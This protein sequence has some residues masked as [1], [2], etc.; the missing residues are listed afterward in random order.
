MA[1]QLAVEPIQ[2]RLAGAPIGHRILYLPSV[3]STMDVARREAEQ[4]APEGTVV[5]AEVQ[6]AGRG[7]FGRRWVSV[8]GE[9]LSFS[10]LL[11]PDRDACAGLSITAPVA[12]VRAIRRVTGLSPALKWP[13][14]VL[15][16]GKKV[17]GILIETA[18]QGDDVQYAIVGIGINVNV[19][20]TAHPE[21]AAAATSL[22]GEL[23][24]SVSR[25]ELFEAVLVDLGEIYGH[26][27]AWT[28]VRQEWQASLETL[29][30]EIQVRWGDQIEEGLAEAVDAEG[31]LLLR[32]H[33]G[34]VI[35]LPGGEVTS[36]VET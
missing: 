7:R 25:E 19:D 11:Y 22:A 26:L 23:G 29:G 30:K 2:A 34:T 15:L 27:T 5:V 10:F 12:V 20:P 32:R 24:A 6:T 33:D 31:N 28:G 35:V 18:F 17:C 36:Q 13:N 16:D 1:V 9:N 21:V 8:Q 4:G 14:D 3:T